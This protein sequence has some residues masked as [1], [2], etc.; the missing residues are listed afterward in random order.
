MATNTQMIE[1]TI[2][3][4]IVKHP[5]KRLNGFTRDVAELRIDCE[6]VEDVATQLNAM[7]NEAVVNRIWKMVYAAR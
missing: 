6:L 1:A 2:E 4:L 3:T 5:Y 7:A